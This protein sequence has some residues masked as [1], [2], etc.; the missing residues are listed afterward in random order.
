[1]C[2]FAQTFLILAMGP[3]DQIRMDSRVRVLKE[4]VSSSLYV[5]DEFAVAE[6]V[7]LRAK[8]KQM[9]AEQSFRSECRLMPPRSFRRDRDARSF[10]LAGSSRVRR[11]SH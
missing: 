7:I 9:I 11:V 10:R 3:V 8:T 2:E 1:M 6:A 5:V 4:L